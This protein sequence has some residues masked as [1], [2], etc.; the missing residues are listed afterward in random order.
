MT[1]KEK[2]LA[3]NRMIEHFTQNEHFVDFD[4]FI[5]TVIKQLDNKTYSFELFIGNTTEGKTLESYTMSKPQH[6]I[7]SIN[8]LSQHRIIAKAIAHKGIKNRQT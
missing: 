8:H 7:D 3:W 4:G 2:Q 1:T 5:T 6:L